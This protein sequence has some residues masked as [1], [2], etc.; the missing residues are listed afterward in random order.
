MLYAIMISNSSDDS[1]KL[2]EYCDLGDEIAM[3]PTVL[4]SFQDAAKLAAE[5]TR[6]MLANKGTWQ[7]GEFS[8][9]HDDCIETTYS[10]MQLTES[11]N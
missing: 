9:V 3:W 1:A 10:I 2:A 4:H 7:S 6:I 11:S 8:V 5:F